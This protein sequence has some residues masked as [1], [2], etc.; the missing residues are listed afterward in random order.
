ML[1]V[2][3]EFGIFEGRVIRHSKAVSQPGPLDCFAPSASPQQLGQIGSSDQDPLKGNEH[4]VDV[5]MLQL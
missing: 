4:P 1:E 2:V 5:W 3:A